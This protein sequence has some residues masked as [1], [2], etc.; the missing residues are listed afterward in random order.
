ML[1]CTLSQ[2]A[3]AIIKSDGTLSRIKLSNILPEIFQIILSICKYIY[4]GKLSLS[5][6]DTLDLIKVLVA[7]SESDKIFNSLNFS[8]IPE[9]L[10]VTTIQSDNRQMSE[11][12]IWEYVL[13]WDGF[14]EYL[15]RIAFLSL[16][17]PNNKPVDKSEYGTIKENKRTIDSK[18]ITYQHIELID[19]LEI[20]DKLAS[21]Y[22]FKLLFRASRDGHSQNKFHQIC[23]N[24]PAHRITNGNYAPY[25]GPSF[26]ENDLIIWTCNNRKKLT[27]CGSKKKYY[28]KPIRITKD[29]FDIE[30]CEVFQIV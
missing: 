7:A 25:F 16:S 24:K 6:Y 18:I 1:C 30:E 8:S 17:D 3:M 28:E 13:K 4:G 27:F 10:L 26:G 2:S 19:R 11:I 29:N 22:K 21:S 15:T 20:T 9:K 12:Q 5:E 23:D 14:K